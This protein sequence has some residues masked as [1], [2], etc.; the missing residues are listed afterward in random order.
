MSKR[1][2]NTF[3][4]G[5][6]GDIAAKVYYDTEY[7]EYTVKMYYHGKHYE[8]D[9]YFTNDKSDAFDTAKYAVANN[10]IHNK[11][12]KTNPVHAH[13]T[14]DDDGDARELLLFITNDANLYRQQ[15]TPIITNLNNRL[16]KGTYD[17]VKAVKL[18]QYLA[19]NGA[20]LYNK[21]NGDG[22]MSLSMFDKPTREI[23]ARGLAEYYADELEP[24]TRAQSRLKKNPISRHSN[25]LS[26]SSEKKIVLHVSVAGYTTNGNK[27]K[28]WIVWA[29]Y[30]N[31]QG[32]I[33]GTGTA[34]LNHILSDYVALGNME[35]ALKQFTELKKQ[36]Y[37]GH[38]R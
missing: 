32:F 34:N 23:V 5:M 21:E 4:D 38:N 27:H 17:A 22:R 10:T 26:D 19:D 31:Y 29:D 33:D 9:D 8:P 2:V 13:R 15:T 12:L 3:T 18:W 11:H 35:I 1:L 6:K 37:Q 16:A 36:K 24:K 25:M 28:G 14:T 30:G 20:K 7:S